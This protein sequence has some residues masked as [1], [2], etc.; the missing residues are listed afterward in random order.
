MRSQV[1]LILNNHYR[2]PSQAFVVVDK[3]AL[4]TVPSVGHRDFGT[5]SKLINNLGNKAW[6]TKN[7][8]S[9]YT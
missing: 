5:L 3:S 4:F 9:T 1:V 6:R 8:S 7:F 2:S